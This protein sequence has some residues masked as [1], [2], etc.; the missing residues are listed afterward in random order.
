MVRRPS[1][2]ESRV[3]KQGAGSR[4][5]RSRRGL[6][7]SRRTPRSKLPAPRL[8]KRPTVPGMMARANRG[9]PR[10]WA[11]EPV[12]GEHG[13]PLPCPISVQIAQLRQCD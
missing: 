12:Q 8:R 4:E 13:N 6:A 9:M 1:T 10:T 11:Q 3:E 7:T 2:A 5:Q